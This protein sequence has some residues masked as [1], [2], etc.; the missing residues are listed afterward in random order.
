MTPSPVTLYSNS[1][2]SCSTP[3]AS[4]GHHPFYLCVYL[5]S[6]KQVFL[7][8]SQTHSILFNWKIAAQSSHAPHPSL[9]VMPSSWPPPP[10]NRRKAVGKMHC[11]SSPLLT[12]QPLTMASVSTSTA[13]TSNTTYHHLAKP[14]GHAGPF[15]TCPSSSMGP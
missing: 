14:Y 15:L 5:L 8:S 10:T 1:Y 11:H 12:A 4:S 7:C 6:L 13:L 9:W 2:P 3:P